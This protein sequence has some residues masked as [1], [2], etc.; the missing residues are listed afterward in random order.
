MKRFIL[1]A[2][3]F[4]VLLGFLAVGLQRNPRELPSPLIGKPVPQF[5]AQRL[6]DPSGTVS[7]ANLRGSVWVLNVWASW[8][9]GCRTEHKDLMDLSRAVNA[10]VIGLNY[11]D[12]RDDALRWLQDHGNP[13][14]QVAFDHDGRIGIDFGVYGVPETFVID[15]HGIIRMKH[16]GPLSA[17]DA[18][19]RVARMV[20]ELANG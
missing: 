20:K 4:I 19:A 16:I 5:A 10:P 2:A 7:P 12:Q 11:K 13:Y 15:R 9:E 18:R 3:L 6:D 14:R 17:P 1:P 8:C